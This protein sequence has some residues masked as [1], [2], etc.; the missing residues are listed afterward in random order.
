MVK[1]IK[2]KSPGRINIIGDHTD[3]MDGYVLP[4]AIGR[5]VTVSI[6]LN[7]TEDMVQVF[8][9]DMQQNH[10]ITL[11]KYEKYQ[12]NGWQNYVIGVLA[13]VNK[14][15]KIPSGFDLSF[16]GDVP[17]GS[18]MSSSAALECS[19]AYAVNA[20]FDLKIPK[21]KLIKACQ[22]AEHNYVGTKCGIMD[23]FSSMMGKADHAILLDCQ[24]LS[25][26][27]YPIQLGEYEIVLLN[28]NV[29]HNL[30]ESQYNLRRSSCEEG[31]SIL[32]A[33]NE[34]I[35]SL[36]DL[37]LKELPSYQQY[38]DPIL[39]RR[40]QH[41]ISENERVLDAAKAMNLNDIE[42]LGHLMYQSHLSLSKDYE[43]SCPELDFLVDQTKQ[44][45][46]VLGSRMMGGGFG[47]CTINLVHATQ[48]EK[49]IE[50]MSDDYAKKFNRDLSPYTVKINS[51]TRIIEK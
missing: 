49:F 11:G 38:L 48:M 21:S 9:Q 5:G 22:L 17:I 24:D 51:G 41:V 23:Q 25:F 31:L 7:G 20:L 14:I 8:A 1:E 26:E 50:S 13:E 47:G 18:G 37:N 29:S 19:I 34:K 46:F 32:H 44:K 2:V 28:S 39:Y 40:C 16:S 6:H 15:K 10:T 3:Y 35:N 42:K 36:R 30:A 4:A 27:Y 43:V 33:E 12:P 45:D